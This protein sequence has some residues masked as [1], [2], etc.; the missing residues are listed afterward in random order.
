[1]GKLECAGDLAVKIQEMKNDLGD[2]VDGLAE[3]KK[4]FADL[5]KDC[6]IKTKLLQEN[7]KYRIQELAQTLTC[8]IDAQNDDGAMELFKKDSSAVQVFLSAMSQ[9]KSEALNM[10][11]CSVLAWKDQFMMHFGL[12]AE[13]KP[14]F[15]T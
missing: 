13:H 14:K 12:K 6:E 4:F 2:M 3:D 10:I 9:M 15:K 1:M 5:N 7:V 8:A 11:N